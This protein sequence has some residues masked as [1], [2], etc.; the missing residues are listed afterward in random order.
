VIDVDTL[1]RQDLARDMAQAVDFAAIAGPTGGSSPV[2]IMNT[3][4]V[5]SFVVA[6]DSGN[7]GVVGDDWALSGPSAGSGRRRL[8]GSDLF[9]RTHPRQLC[10]VL[11]CHSVCHSY[12]GRNSLRG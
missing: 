5:Q 10:V 12:L 2:G 9:L 8:Q 1:V 3:T 6:A 7:G 4:G 11:V